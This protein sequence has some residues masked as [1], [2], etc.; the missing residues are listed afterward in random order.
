MKRLWILGLALAL[1]LTMA[2]SVWGTGGGADDPAIS[3][4]YLEDVFTPELESAYT[5][6]INGGLGGTYRTQLTAFTEEAA[7]RKLSS[8]EAAADTP[9]KLAGTILLKKGDMLTAAPGCKITVRSGSITADTSYLVDVTHGR[10]VTKYATLAPGTLYMMGDTDSGELLAASATCE[11]TVSGVARLDP[12]GATDYGSMAQALHT[13]GLFQGTAT[14]YSLENTANRA[15]GLVMFLRLLGLEE[16]ALSYSGSCPFA[17]VPAS[18]WAYR[19]VAYAYSQGLTTGTSAARFAPEGAITCQHYAT[20]LLR[21]LH[22]DE[23]GDFTYSTAVA[24]LAELGLF[25]Q[26]ETAALSSGSFFRYKMVYLSYYA[27]FGVDQATGQLLM[28]RLT[29][30]GAVD[31]ADLSRGLLQVAGKR[32]S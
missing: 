4:S 26:A 2:G 32:I 3:L 16:E 31:T 22:Y 10:A 6:A 23:G 7:A 28:N 11:L 29:R 20:F 19:Y 8:Q 9:Q 25:N 1:V 18:H 24:D 14:G 30:S 13:M 21:A 27:L 15:Q 5:A 17:D 12:S